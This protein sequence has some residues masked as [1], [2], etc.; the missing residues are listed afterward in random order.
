V[1]REP[2]PGPPSEPPGLP[3]LHTW[4]AVYVLV[5]GWFVVVLIVLAVF[6][7]VFS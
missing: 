4:R 1:T 7:R 2:R 5:L 6:T 3:G